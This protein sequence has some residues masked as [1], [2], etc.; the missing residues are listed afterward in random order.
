M[1]GDHD[2]VALALGNACSHRAHAD[3]RNQLDAD[4]GFGGHVFQVVDQL[5]QVFD[6]INIVVRRRRDQA[7]ARHRITQ[8]ADVIRHLVT[9]QLSALAR[10]GALGHLDLDLVGAGQVFGG[11]TKTPGRDLL[12]LGAHR[13][14][15]V[16]GVVDLEQILAQQVGHGLALGDGNAFE[17][18]AVARRVF[19]AFAGVALAAY[20]V[21]GN[22]QGGMRLGGNGTQRHRTGG[23]TLDDFGGTF[24]LVQ[25]NRLGRIDLELEQAA[26]GQV[27][28]ALVVD[29]LGVFLVGAEVVGAGA[30][31]QFGNRI[32]RP[33][34]LLAA[35]PPGIFATGVER[36]GQH[37]VGAECGAVH[38][39]GLFGNLEYAYAFHPAGR[40]SE[41]LVHGLA[42]QANRFKQL[43]AAVAH[44]G[45]H[46]HLG[47][48]LGQ[49]FANR[50]D[51][52]VNRLVGT[53]VAAEVLVEVHQGFHRQVRVYRFSPKTCE[54][55]E[56]VNLARRAGFHDQ[57]GGGAQAFADQVLVDR[58]QG[59]EGGNRH[60]IG[61][62]AFVA[63]DQDVVA[64][65]DR[66]HRL[67]A[68]RRQ[69]GLHALVAPGQRIGDVQ[70][71][72]AEFAVRVLGDV[73]QLGHIG[74]V[75]HGLRNLQPH[76]RVDLVDVQQV[77]LGTDEGDQR[78]HDRFADRVDRRV[79]HL[80]EELFE[81]VVQRLV[82]VGQHG[83]GAVVAHGAQRLFS[84]SGHGRH[85]KLHIFLGKTKRLLAVQQA[86]GR[87][88][89]GVNR[90]AGGHVVE[91][92]AQVVDPLLV[93]LAVS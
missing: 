83:Q 16:Q 84:G 88:L 37:R 18:V 66:V 76:G 30:V 52:V 31:L 58:R 13:V 21:H 91:L 9:G 10:L 8:H 12:D 25:R 38:A 87:H 71:G 36:V 89:T 7:H 47:H 41:I 67:R 65:S 46:A 45:R 57:S 15:R 5:R 20:A 26:Q 53:Q 74:K 24:H 50:L 79:G 49:A 14:A 72:A 90:A 32:R 69:L 78:H 29:D 43:R 68:Q 63:D 6:G 28:A 60:L 42:G 93:G 80:G 23:K 59:H 48:D 3:F 34:M 64:A 81:V 4:A 56:M 39:N 86:D 92:D 22:G 40:A 77:G 61:A 2:V 27:A 17:F 70:R 82:L 73:A 11:D 44:I 1:A 85:Q 19:A 54:H 75:Q 62:H 51:V 35:R 33:H 55:G